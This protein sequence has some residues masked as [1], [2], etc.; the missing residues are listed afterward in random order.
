V[1]E[2]HLEFKKEGIGMNHTA[3][4]LKIPNLAE[5]KPIEVVDCAAT[6]ESSL[7]P[8]SKPTPPIP[9]PISINRLLP[10]LVHEPN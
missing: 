10:P 5:S 9:I 4:A 6:F 3:H 2:E 1:V 7:W 8:I